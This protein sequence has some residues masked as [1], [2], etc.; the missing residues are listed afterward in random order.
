M[1]MGKDA[2]GLT[3]AAFHFYPQIF[4]YDS[5]KKNQKSDLVSTEVY[6]TIHPL[7][8]SLQQRADKIFFGHK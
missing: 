6:D 7:K 5:L 1:K 8:N 4:F 3:A 2:S